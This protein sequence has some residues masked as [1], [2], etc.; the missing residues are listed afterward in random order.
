MKLFSVNCT[1]PVGLEI[2]SKA[3]VAANMEIRESWCYTRRSGAA[4][5]PGNSRWCSAWLNSR[6]DS[7]VDPMRGAVCSREDSRRYDV[8]SY[9]SGAAGGGGVI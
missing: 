3:R 9:T 6:E 2:Y 7:G 5:I 4:S 8:L 1:T